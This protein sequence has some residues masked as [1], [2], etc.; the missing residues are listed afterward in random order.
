MRVS[1]QVCACRQ[2]RG[3]VP[4]GVCAGGCGAL[5][6]HHPGQ[7]LRAVQR[8]CKPRFRI[9]KGVTCAWRGGGGRWGQQGT[10]VES[11]L[12]GCGSSEGATVPM[13]PLG[14]KETKELD[15]ST[16]LRVSADL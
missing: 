6:R 9:R 10:A 8:V 11:G 1:G 7:H 13:I 4:R 15:W 14:L 3:G 5:A 16:P 2:R 12:N